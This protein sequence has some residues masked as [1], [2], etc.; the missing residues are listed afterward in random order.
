LRTRRTEGVRSRVVLGGVDEKRPRGPHRHVE[1]KHRQGRHH[2]ELPSK[3]PPSPGP[4][5]DHRHRRQQRRA[6]TAASIFD[7]LLSLSPSSP[8]IRDTNASVARF[9]GIGIPIGFFLF[10][11]CVSLWVGVS[12]WRLS[13][14]GGERFEK[15]TRREGRGDA[16]GSRGVTGN[17]PKRFCIQDAEGEGKARRKQ[18]KKTH[19]FTFIG[20]AN[21][22]E[23]ERRESEKKK[24]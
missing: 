20:N 6:T 7:L 9:L 15:R 21:S 23:G 12:S 17:A 16:M 11:C 22:K 14:V 3:K 8:E 18:Q 24:K 2:P 13:T 5:V 4:L 10:S 19:A 1:D